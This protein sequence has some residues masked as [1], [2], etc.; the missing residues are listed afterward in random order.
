MKGWF[1]FAI[2]VSIT[3]TLMLLTGAYIGKHMPAVK[4]T[5]EFMIQEGFLK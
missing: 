1:I 5:S 2:W 4:K 3:F